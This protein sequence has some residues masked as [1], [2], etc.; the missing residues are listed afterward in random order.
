MEYTLSLKDKLLSSP[1][2][3]H[4]KASSS[5]E[6]DFR[7]D[8]RLESAHPVLIRLPWSSFKS[9][10]RGKPVENGQSLDTSSIKRI[11]F[12]ARR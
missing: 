7:S 5:W 11:A 3:G 2:Q 8:C 9:K 6:C 1:N 10:Y 4:G 12:M